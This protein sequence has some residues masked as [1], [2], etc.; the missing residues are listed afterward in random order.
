MKYELAINNVIWYNSILLI[1]KSWSSQ[2]VSF[3][4]EYL[5]RIFFILSGLGKPFGEVKGSLSFPLYWVNLDKES[6]QHYQ[7]T[8][9]QI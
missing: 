2:V 6:N 5:P 4:L 1:N 7:N 9:L 3:I 8:S